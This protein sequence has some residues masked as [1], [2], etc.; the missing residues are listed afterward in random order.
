MNVIDDFFV[1]CTIHNIE[2][3]VSGNV[4]RLIYQPVADFYRKI[5][6]TIITYIELIMRINTKFIQYF[7]I[8]FRNWSYSLYTT[9]KHQNKNKNCES[10]MNPHIHYEKKDK[11]FEH[12]FIF[13]FTIYS[14]HTYFSSTF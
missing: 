13:S 4:G 9:V 2:D 14:F 11:F 10:Q 12:K 5:F 3:I 6:M 8:Q 7:N 1:L